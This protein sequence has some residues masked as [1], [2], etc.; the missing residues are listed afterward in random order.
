[1]TAGRLQGWRVLVTRQPEQAAGWSEALTREGATV[2][3]VPLIETVAPEDPGPLADAVAGLAEYDWVAFTSA[4]AVRA[5]ADRWGSEPLPARLR[6][7]T[8][9]PA[10][11]R[12]VSE[13]FPGAEVSVTPAAD[14]RAEGLVA[15]FANEPI[16]GRRV[17]LP[18][19]A[20]AR[21]TL[22]VGLVGLGAR[23]EVVTAYRT[24][25]PPSA[26]AR[27]AAALDAR[28]DVVALASPSAVEGFV[29]ACPPGGPRPPVIAI[30]PVTEKAAREAG[31]RV[32]ATAPEPGPAGLVE[33]LAGL[34]R[35][36]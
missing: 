29:A 15:A 10:T 32:A 9:G 22:A 1:M 19:S 11:S 36:V 2:V 30:G 12:A 33:A 13:A 27:I 31:L 7:A 3:E 26:P 8:V 28:V 25:T 24:V 6:V 14:A 21:D 20:L 16:R 4:N 35:P 17:L 18:Q 23:V 5:V 34:T